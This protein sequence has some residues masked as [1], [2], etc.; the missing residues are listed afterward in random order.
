[1][2]IKVERARAVAK[3]IGETARAQLYVLCHKLAGDNKLTYN[4]L[5]PI[6]LDAFRGASC[7][8][9]MEERE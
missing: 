5:L 3:E 8:D 1:M 6:A 7:E 2:D 4:E 9:A